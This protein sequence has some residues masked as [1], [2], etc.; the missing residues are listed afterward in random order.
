[1]CF[2]RKRRSLKLGIEMVLGFVELD[3]PGSLCQELV[4]TRLKGN[5]YKQEMRKL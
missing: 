5:F 3:L 2:L 4:E 1:M